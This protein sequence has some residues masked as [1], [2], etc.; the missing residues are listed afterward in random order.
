MTE[1]D[2]LVGLLE[3]AQLSGWLCHHDRRSDLARQ[4]GQPGFPDIIAVHPTRGRICAMEVKSERGTFRPGQADWL[5]AFLGAGV[6]T[7]VVRP[8]TYD[9]AITYLLDRAHPSGTH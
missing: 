2:L 3:A 9:E 1:N 8:D 7:F 4:Q 5:A 6:D